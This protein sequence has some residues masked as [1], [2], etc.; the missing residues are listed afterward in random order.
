MTPEQ[1]LAILQAI[2]AL[3]PLGEAVVGLVQTALASHYGA[4]SW[5]ALEAEIQTNIATTA[6]RMGPTNGLSSNA[7]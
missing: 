7:D 6:A 5:Q 1:A 4:E 2:Q 3:A